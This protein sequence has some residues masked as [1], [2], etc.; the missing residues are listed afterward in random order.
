M[1]FSYLGGLAFIACAL[2]KWGAVEVRRQ[3]SEV[4]GLTLVGVAWLLISRNLFPWFGLSIADDVK[5][6][7]NPAALIALSGAT[8][9]VA[10]IYAAGSLGEGPSYWN[11]IF[12]AGMGTAG[13]FVLWLVLELG[14]CVS[15]SIA[16]ERDLASG[17]RLGAFMLAAGLILGRAVA[18]DWHS[19]SATVRD[20]IQDGWPAGVLCLIAVLT[21]HLL[22]PS[23][24][25]PFPGWLRCG[26]LPA[27]LYL[28]CAGAW[29]FHLGRWEGMPE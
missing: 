19:E 5:D 14:G 24:T 10:I 7:R 21:E 3:S 27:L 22:R 12:S 9:A 18:G 13:F 16:E 23:R 17:I 25:R 15:A 6:R 8:C 28:G 20:F 11:N 2:W 29:V 4:F 26:L 1:L